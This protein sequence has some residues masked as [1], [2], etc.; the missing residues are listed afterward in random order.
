MLEPSANEQVW[1]FLISGGIFMAFIAAC[2]FLGIAVSIHRALTLKWSSVIPVNLRNDLYRCGQI[3]DEGQASYLLAA[4]RASD[5]PMGR[6]GRVALS[7]DFESRASASEA[8]ETT[9]KEQMVTLEKGMGVLEV[10][11]TIAPL[12]GLLGTVSGLVSVFATL[13]TSGG[14]VTDP[15]QIAAGIS[16]ALNTTIAGLVVAVIT[17][18]LHSFFTRRLE[19]VAAR[20]EVIVRQLLTEFYKYGGPS[21]Y[22]V[23][24]AHAGDVEKAPAQSLVEAI[25]QSGREAEEGNFL[26]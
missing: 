16:V 4:L 23:E 2:S 18:I 20:F 21:M 13:G 14:D 1:N 17:V 9:A 15:S 12:L 25:K 11:I 6:I 24:A 19:R 26:S 10:V 22:E 5:S 7:P 8:V 3:F